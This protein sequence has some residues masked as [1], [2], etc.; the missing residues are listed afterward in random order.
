MVS[1]PFVMK[2]INL[3][4]PLMLFSLPLFGQAQSTAKPKPRVV[5]IG[6]NGMELDVI[7][8]LLL[9]GKMP[10]LS[11]VIKKGAYG[12]LRT[13]SAPNCPRVYSTLFTSTKPEEH[14][15][16]GFIVGGITAN[17]NMLKQEP[18]W[19]L[20]SK[21]G[22]TVGMA[23]VPAT[24]PV[25]PVNGFMISGML[26]RGKNCEDGVLCAPKLSEVQGGDAVYPA[27]LKAELLKN[28]GD[29]YIDCE[30][31]PAAM[32]LK[33]HETEVIDAWLKKVQL[34]RDQQTQ[35]FDYLLDHHPTEF[36]WLAQS[37]EDR[38]GHWLYPIAPYHAGYNPK[39]NSV[40]PDA[41]PSQYIAF[42]KVLGAILKHTDDNTYVFIVS[43]HG[44][45]PLREFEETD[46]H[47]H[48]DHEKTTP[49]IA[50]HDFA[51]GDDVP[52]SFF[53]MGPGIK[54]DLRLMGFEAS[55][56]DLA[57]TIL[58]IYGIQQPVQMRGHV[59]SEIFEKSD[60]TV[61]QK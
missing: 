2:S 14:G 11:S 36:T 37:C 60:K 44:I 7:R 22:V 10:N 53:A 32:D 31:M 8:P 46:P 6:V 56:Y 23:N 19:S 33:G 29:F 12:K 50:K 15:V 41:F 42:D 34:I 26:T 35:L 45:K 52:G 1:R 38:A 28:V 4:L 17:T 54:H 3:I 13:L 58:H 55:V 40:R 24:F 30:R 47:A 48:M 9:Q 39:I 16:S 18:I 57:P 5:V 27:A 51:D 20:L 43:D 59:L 25:M 49:V 21:D 61:A